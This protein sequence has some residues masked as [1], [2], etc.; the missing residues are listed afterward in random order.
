MNGNICPACGKP[1]MPYSRFL[2]QAEPYK[3]AECDSCGVK[4]RR[5]PRVYVYLL[6]MFALLVVMSVRLMEGMAAAGYSE[7]LIWIL[8][9]PWLVCWV[10]LIN[11]WSWRFIGWVEANKE[12]K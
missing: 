1:V 11:Y 10:L 6:V 9:V 7:V 4:L 12:N 5:S 3:L 2:R 8:A